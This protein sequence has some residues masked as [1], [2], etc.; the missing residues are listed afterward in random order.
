MP[1][2]NCHDAKVFLGQ[3]RLDSN[4]F[5]EVAPEPVQPEDDDSIAR[6]YPRHQL[7]PGGAGTGTASHLAG[8]DVPFPDP[9]L[10][11]YVDLRLQVPGGVVGLA[12]PGVAVC[13]R[14]DVRHIGPCVNQS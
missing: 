13:D 10:L 14:D 6:P 11:E 5:V 2:P 7:V 4:S 3:L 12:D 9:K 8:E 1:S